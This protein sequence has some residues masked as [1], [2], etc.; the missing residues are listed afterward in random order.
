MIDFV[1]NCR[2]GIVLGNGVKTAETV[3][4]VNHEDAKCHASFSD[5]PQRAQQRMTNAIAS[6]GF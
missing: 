1:Q 4:K 2:H 5:K 3:S 6:A